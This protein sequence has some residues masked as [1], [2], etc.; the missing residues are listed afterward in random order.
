MAAAIVIRTTA[1]AAPMLAKMTNKSHQAADLRIG[2]CEVNR[3]ITPE[4]RRRWWSAGQH[5]ISYRSAARSQ[6]AAKLGDKP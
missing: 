1:I 2:L 5:E 3:E 6:R 4:D